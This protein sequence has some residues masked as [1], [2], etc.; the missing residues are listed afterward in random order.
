MAL[1][2]VEGRRGDLK[3]QALVG[4]SV[5]PLAPRNGGPA[6]SLWPRQTDRQTRMQ[7]CFCVF[8][9]A[10]GRRGP[11]PASESPSMSSPQ[12]VSPGQW[13]AR[14][15][16]RPAGWSSRRELLARRRLLAAQGLGKPARTE[17]LGEWIFSVPGTT[18]QGRSVSRWS[19]GR[20]LSNKCLLHKITTWVIAFLSSLHTKSS[21][22]REGNS[23][24][25]SLS[26]SLLSRN[27]W[28]GGSIPR[29]CPRVQGS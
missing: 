6:A 29:I 23:L 8:W 17:A 20:H 27:S 16:Y 18:L 26:V 19:R 12:P 22:K 5:H 4:S 2:S 15:R 7:R 9:Q 13:A 11:N 14:A 21:G 25:A 3:A 1:P 28:D 10:G 24:V